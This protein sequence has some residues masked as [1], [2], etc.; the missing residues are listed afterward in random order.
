MNYT[1]LDQRRDAIDSY[2]RGDMTESERTAFEQQMAR[3]EDLAREVNYVMMV[4]RSANSVASKKAK[5]SR[6]NRA[7]ATLTLNE[8]RATAVCSAPLSTASAKSDK[9]TTL[10]VIFASAAGLALVLVCGWWFLFRSTAPADTDT[11]TDFSTT[12]PMDMQSAPA[13]APSPY[14]D[15]QW[16]GGYDTY[17]IQ[18]LFESGQYDKAITA[19]DAE[20]A[21]TIIDP[22]LPAEEQQYMR[23][24]IADKSYQLRWWLIQSLVAN[25]STDRAIT[26]LHDFVNLDGEY[27]VQARSLLNQLR[28]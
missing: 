21:D 24:L 7:G 11:D 16:R 6:W 2:V 10:R 26:E 5:M 3:D 13:P 17:Q 23:Q 27:Q 15:D 14:G 18:A 4:S 1:D 9:R 20:L 28:K 25:G 22:M 19:I 12:A 8:L